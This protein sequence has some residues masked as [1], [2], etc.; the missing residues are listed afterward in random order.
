MRSSTLDTLPG[1]VPAGQVACETTAAG[2]ARLATLKAMLA[3]LAQL[4]A[5]IVA[6]TLECPPF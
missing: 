4:T 2:N 3:D 6:A 1:Q 5:E